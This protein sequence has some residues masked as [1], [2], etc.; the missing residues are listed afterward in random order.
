M[1]THSIS[2]FTA[3]DIAT[4]RPALASLLRDCVLAGASINFIAPFDLNQASAFWQH[5]VEPGVLKGTLILLVARDEGEWTGSVQLDYD[6]PPN[7]PHRAEVRKLMVHPAFRRKGIARQLMQQIEAISA[8][9]GRTLITLD[10]RTGSEAEPLYTA[11]GYL[12]VGQIP[13]YALDVDGAGLHGTTLMY[14][15]L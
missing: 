9:L 13:G 8:A 4:H 14:K 3:D 10:T 11:L 15:Q 6:T 5:K 7:Q 12:T 2:Q 1:P